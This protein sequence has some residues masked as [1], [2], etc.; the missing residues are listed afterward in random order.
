MQRQVNRHE[1]MVASSLPLSARHV[2]V[3]VAG[4]E[5]ATSANVCW[6]NTKGQVRGCWHH[7][8]GMPGSMPE[9]QKLNT[10]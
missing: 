3:A 4:L 1:V 5:T 9:F 6:N 7:Q 10:P 2:H 8:C